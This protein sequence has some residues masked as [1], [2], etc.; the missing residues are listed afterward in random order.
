M[1]RPSRIKIGDTFKTNE[2]C[3]FVILDKSMFD[4]Y[5]T[6]QFLDKHKHI[7]VAEPTPILKGQI[8]NPFHPSV[9]GIGYNGFNDLKEEQFT[10]TH[11]VNGKRVFT[12]EYEA[13]RG[14]FKRSYCSKTHTRQPTYIGCSV[15]ERWHN[16]QVFAE[17][18]V[19]QPGYTE[20][21]DIDKDLLIK[22]NKVYSEESCLLLPRPINALLTLADYVGDRFLPRGIYIRESGKYRVELGNDGP[23][24]I[25][26]TVTSIKEAIVLR[27]AYTQ[28]RIAEIADK[29]ND[30]IPEHTMLKIK[31]RLLEILG[32]PTDPVED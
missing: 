6:I 18:Y 26:K 12:Q 2:G 32:I 23:N 7:R 22:N 29:Y 28:Q 25:T 3:E 11:V 31:E 10:A 27:N 15:D 1:A 24:R 13:W 21:W 8:K 30:V 14:M 20:R 5:W 19:N 4:N 16:F 17:W 9:Y